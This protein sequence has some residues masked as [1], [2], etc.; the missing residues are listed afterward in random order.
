[1][2]N[3]IYQSTI[4]KIGKFATDTLSDDLLITFKQ[5]APSDLADYCFIH[6]H[7]KLNNELTVKQTLVLGNT[8]YQI[9]AVGDIATINLREL[10]HITIRFD[11]SQQA[12]LP[13]SVHVDGK[14]PLHLKAGDLIMIIE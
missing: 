13:G 8:H 11:A 12:E 4:Q 7:D 1:M 6:S 3:I 10:G 14:T 9:T 5:G 2:S